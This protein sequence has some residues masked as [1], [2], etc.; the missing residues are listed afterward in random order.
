[1]VSGV[2]PASHKVLV[3]IQGVQRL[4]LR[5]ALVGSAT[6]VSPVW[7]DPRVRVAPWVFDQLEHT[8][9][10][11]E[12]L[13]MLAS[14]LP[15]ASPLRPVYR[16]LDVVRLFSRQALK[17]MRSAKKA[18]GFGGEGIPLE[19]PFC[20]QVDGVVFGALARVLSAAVDDMLK[21]SCGVVHT[22]I[23]HSLI[24][25]VKANLRRYIASGVPAEQA[26]LGGSGPSSPLAS[27][28]LLL[29]RLAGQPGAEPPKDVPVS[30][31]VEAANA[32]DLGLEVFYP[33]TESRK[34]LLS[35]LVS[36]GGIVEVNVL[37]A[38]ARD[39]TDKTPEDFRFERALLLLQSHAARQKWEYK[40]LGLFKH[41]LHFVVSLPSADLLTEFL[42]TTLEKLLKQAGLPEWS[43]PEGCSQPDVNF[44]IERFLNFDRKERLLS[45]AGVGWV[46]LYPT[47]VGSFTG[48]VDSVDSYIAELT[49]V[50]EAEDTR[51]ALASE[52]ALA[53]ATA[54]ALAGDAASGVVA[55]A[56]AGAGAPAADPVPVPVPDV[57]RASP[58][59]VDSLGSGLF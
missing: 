3:S 45:E 17:S 5:V 30:V 39:P 16:V 47:G 4:D 8:A 56:G 10:M 35:L 37:W 29:S 46:R 24:T 48:V 32:L 19:T 7:V 15:A 33:S 26:N 57:D 1:V 58:S 42:T 36:R 41:S 50:S 28:Q 13:A 43:F 18:Q 25:I 21:H 31:C 27:L 11:G 55:G 38:P 22:D 14:V 49:R 53:A 51:A 59:S 2:K 6:S 54:A 52:K 12:N 44:T 23:V 20:V 9:K 40:T 34:E